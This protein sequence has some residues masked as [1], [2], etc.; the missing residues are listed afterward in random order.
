MVGNASTDI[1]VSD[2][3]DM[4]TLIQNNLS[5]T[6]CGSKIRTEF[7]NKIYSSALTIFHCR[8]VEL[9]RLV[10]ARNRELGLM[11]FNHIDGSVNIRSTIFKE[12]NQRN[13]TS[14]LLQNRCMEVVG[15]Y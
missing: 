6:F 8:I 7:N 9:D 15:S 13:I 10:I 14:S 4:V 12:N 1:V 3:N 2:I 11:I 5:L